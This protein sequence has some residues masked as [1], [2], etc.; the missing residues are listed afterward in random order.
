M[1]SRRDCG[2]GALAGVGTLAAVEVDVGVAVAVG[3]VGVFEGL[4]LV[5]L[6]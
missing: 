4:G 2:G 1:N 6:E 3:V 5:N